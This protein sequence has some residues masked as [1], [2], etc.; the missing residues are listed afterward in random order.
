MKKIKRRDFMRQ[1]AAGSLTLVASKTALSHA[2]TIL[3]Q[4]SV[5]PIVVAS[6][7]GNRYK[8]TGNETSVQKAFTMMAQG[9]DVL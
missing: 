3:I 4:N 8:H 7:N 2:P 1:T 9:T 6:A 5:K